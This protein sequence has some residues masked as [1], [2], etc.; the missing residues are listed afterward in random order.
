MKLLLQLLI[1]LK[2]AHVLASGVFRT[3]KGDCAPYGPG[4][5]VFYRISTPSRRTSVN[6]PGWR[7]QS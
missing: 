5:G 2:T 7:V 1:I 4:H 6:S 3:E